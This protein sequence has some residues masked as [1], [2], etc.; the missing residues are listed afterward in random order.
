MTKIINAALLV[1]G[2]DQQTSETEGSAEFILLN[3]EWPLIVETE[4][5]GGKYG[6]SRQQ[7]FLQ[8]RIDGKFGYSDAYLNPGDA[9][10]I[11]S[12][13][14][15]DGETRVEP[16]W[17]QDGTHVHVE[18]AD[19]GVYIDYVVSAE[20]HLWSATFCE[21]IKW[22]L[23]ASLYRAQEDHNA[24]AAVEQK[25]A[26]ILQQA[27]TNS[28]KQRSARPAFRPGQIARARFSRG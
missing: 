2:Y 7:A 28:A 20:E 17:I 11:R 4:L 23:V 5:E 18:G 16:H 6:F 9:M 25:A 27:R 8:T 22:S 26:M 19:A 21:G 15:L 3:S 12:L 13:W 10:H 1:H 24:A 14:Y